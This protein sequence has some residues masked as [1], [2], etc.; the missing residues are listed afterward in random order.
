ML[1][2]SS[3]RSLP[4]HPCINL[5]LNWRRHLNPFNP[6]VEYN[7]FNGKISPRH[8]LTPSHV[9]L[10]VIHNLIKVLDNIFYFKT[11]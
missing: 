7:P 3:A 9:V 6:R 8:Y 1:T 4:L 5:H 2:G 10:A 11:L